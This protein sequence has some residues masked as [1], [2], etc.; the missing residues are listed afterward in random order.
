MGTICDELERENARLGTELAAKVAELSEAR[1][2]LR[3][4][5]KTAA[6]IPQVLSVVTRGPAV[7]HL[8]LLSFPL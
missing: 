1:D 5:N 7:C 2:A 6:L 8:T 4:V 3:R